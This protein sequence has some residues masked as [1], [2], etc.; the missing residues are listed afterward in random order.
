M[1]E[2]KEYNEYGDKL[3]TYDI[4]KL[5][6]KAGFEGESPECYAILHTSGKEPIIC[7]EWSGL[8]PE[9]MQY[10]CD[11]PTQSALQKW[12]REEHNIIVESNYL[13]NIQK[14]RCLYK[15]MN[16][17]P[18]KFKT[19]KEL[20]LAIDKYYSKIDFDTYEEA[21]ELGLNLGLEQIIS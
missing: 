12:I 4:A 18:K 7:D 20:A 15:P 11:R 5:A 14:Y 6:L 10:L 9:P 3:V 16:I 17:I 1:K 21:L 2:H 8:I 13:P 19:R